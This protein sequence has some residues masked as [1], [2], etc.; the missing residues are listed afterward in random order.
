M[1]VE[2][3]LFFSMLNTSTKHIILKTISLMEKI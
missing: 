2:H 1:Q 3:T